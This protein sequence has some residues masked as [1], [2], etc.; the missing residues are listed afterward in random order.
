MANIERFSSSSPQK[1]GSTLTT[2]F[3]EEANQED[4]CIELVISIDSNHLSIKEFSS[5][6]D[7]IYRIDGMTSELGYKRYV[8]IPRAQIEISEIRFGSLLIIIEKFIDELDGK[9]LVIIGLCLKYLPQV[10][11]TSTEASVH[12]FDMLNKR[13]DY[14]EKK[15]RRKLRKSIRDSIKEDEA[16]QGINKNLKEKL[17]DLLDE[18]YVKN[19][20]R[21]GPASR[22]ASKS[23]KSIKIKTKRKNNNR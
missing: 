7:F 8:Q 22:F 10:I 20:Q 12:L 21:I 4:N 2:L 19:T 13:E 3:F 11:K 14:L 17:V 1:I 6:L 16:L 9:T 23:V 15:D 18:M 5:Y